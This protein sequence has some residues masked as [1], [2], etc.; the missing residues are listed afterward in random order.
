MK[1][2]LFVFLLGFALFACQTEKKAPVESLNEESLV[3]DEPVDLTQY[4]YV[5]THCQVGSHEPGKCACG[6]D[7]EANPDFAGT[8]DA[9]QHDH[10]GEDLSQYEY[11]CTHCNKGSHEAGKCDCG[12]EMEKNPDFKAGA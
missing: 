6:M 9:D 3:V 8:V 2:L 10:E 4:E 11:I 1:N 7:Y 5:C 12:M